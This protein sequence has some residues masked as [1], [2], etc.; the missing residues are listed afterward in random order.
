MHVF[1]VIILIIVVICFSKLVLFR[2]AQHFTLKPTT[3]KKK[4]TQ[5]K[6]RDEMLE[7]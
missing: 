4:Y 6:M 5:I 7:Y 1:I 2:A 3:T